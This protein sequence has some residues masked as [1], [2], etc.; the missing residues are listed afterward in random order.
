M[1]ENFEFI[2][3]A[4]DSCV[5]FGFGRDVEVCANRIQT[6]LAQSRNQRPRDAGEIDSVVVH[7]VD[8]LVLA[9]HFIQES[10]LERYVPC[11]KYA[12]R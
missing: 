8:D 7:V 2:L 3:R 5:G 12:F 4:T 9:E 11:A 10:K 1:P 6:E